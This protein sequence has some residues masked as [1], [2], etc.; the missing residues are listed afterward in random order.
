MKNNF[1][2]YILLKKKGVNSILKNKKPTRSHKIN[3]YY[4]ITDIILVKGEVK[5][6][7]LVWK[8]NIL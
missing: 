7:D 3:F 8:V 2:D 6:Q 4:W 5:L 1:V